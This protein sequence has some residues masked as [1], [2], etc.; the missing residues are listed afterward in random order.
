MHFKIEATSLTITFDL[1]TSKRIIEI[2][3]STIS[4]EFI[5]DYAIKCQTVLKLDINYGGIVLPPLVR[6]LC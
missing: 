6:R 5:I 4:K 2:K 3:T 1:M